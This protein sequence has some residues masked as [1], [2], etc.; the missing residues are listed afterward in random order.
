MEDCETDSRDGVSRCERRDS[1]LIPAVN[2]S[3]SHTQNRQQVEDPTALYAIHIEKNKQT[4]VKT[5]QKLN[6]N[7]MSQIGYSK[8]TVYI[9]ILSL[10]TLTPTVAI[11]VKL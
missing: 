9:C 2:A 10:N 11:W 3:K 6:Y 4:T 8:F 1:G 7:C 5:K